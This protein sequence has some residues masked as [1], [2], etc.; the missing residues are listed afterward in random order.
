MRLRAAL[1]A[2]AAALGVAAFGGTAAAQPRTTLNVGMA[3]QDVGRLDP[4]FAVS[5]IDRVAVAWMF[6]GLVRFKPGSINPAEIEP[7]LAERWEASADGRTWTFVLRRGVQFHGGFGEVTAEDVAFSLRKAAQSSTSAFSGDFRAFESVE[8]VDPHTVRIRLRENVPSLLGLVTNYA[9]G[10]IVSKRAVEQ[11]GDAFMRAPIGS[12]PF[13]FASVTPNQSLE[14]AA[15]EGYFRGAPQ[16]KRISYRFIPSDASRDLAFQNRE[17]DINYGRAQTAWIERTRRLPNVVVDVFEP[18]ELA[19][20]NINTRQPPF[21]DIRVR[22]AVAHAID[23]SELVRWRGEAV[24]REGQSLVPR[25]Y[26]GF[27][28]DVP[29]PGFDQARARSL[30]A[31]A[32]HPNGISVRV[33]HTQLPEMLSAMQVVQQQLRR[34]GIT[35]DLQV[36]EHAT[37]HQ[38][39]RQDLSPL[40]YYAAARFP[41]ADIYLTQFY[42]GRSI[43]KTPTAV[44]NFSHCAMADAEIDAARVETDPQKQLALWAAAQRK[45]VEA[46]CGVPLF[47][48]LLVFARYGNVDYGYELKGSMSLGP[49]ITEATRFR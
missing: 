31:E 21:D 11:K 14:L 3:A 30:L 22:R 20:L 27:T 12:G 10:Y 7:D 15:H 46:V 49:L 41:V 24:A 1:L 36:V 35:L 4:H 2:G 28:P 25:G 13:A 42:H 18:A 39:I 37:F 16:I 44:T 19:I 40:V 45:L 17:L 33:I 29:L 34:V 32:G 48:T 43:V 23:R 9:G 6:N 47:E 26:L 5:T 38:Q 8:V